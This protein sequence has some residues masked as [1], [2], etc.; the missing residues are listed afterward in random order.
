MDL[1]IGIIGLPNVGKSTLFQK[2]TKQN[3]NIANYPFATIDPNVGVVEVPDARLQ[4]LAQISKS[5]KIIPAV[6]E[7]Y[8]IAGLVRGA[9]KGD[10]LGNQ[11]LAHIR[12]VKAILHIVRCF[13]Q[14]DIIHVEGNVSPE[15]D[16][17]II[18]TE[19]IFKDFE[20][21]EKRL[22]KLEG[23]VRSGDKQAKINFDIL[24]KAKEMLN[25]G[26]LLLP[27]K[28]ELIIK[29]LQ[30]LTAKPQIILFNGAINDIPESAKQKVKNF[31]FEFMIFDLNSNVNLNPLIQTAYRILDLISF[32][33]TGEDETRSW[34][35][36][37]GTKAPQAAGVI[38]TDFEKKFIKAEVI[39][40]N[41]LLQSGSWNNA[42]QKG[43]IKLE[44][45][46]YIVQ[47]GDVIIFK[48]G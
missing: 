33:T 38:H 26:K 42:K 20:T 11:F 27:L 47:D 48:H 34:T 17:D 14:Q 16:I 23:E 3:V 43:L 7:F 2:L 15:R 22:K 35:I 46:D 45:K 25:Q 18:E 1:S 40:W 6:I 39:N 19:L 31:G 41:I 4:K 13:K 21:I 37:K 28:D 29:E 5:E 10:G 8:D 32:F 36:I 30:L 24:T 12:N 9:Y 44:G